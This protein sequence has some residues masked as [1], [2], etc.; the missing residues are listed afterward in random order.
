[1][2]LEQPSSSSSSSDK[3][4]KQSSSSLV[5]HPKKSIKCI[6]NGWFTETETFWPGQ[7]FSLALE[8]F[9]HD[10][11]ILFHDH[12]EHQEILV[13]QSAQYGTTLVLDGVIQLTQRDEFSYHEMMTH[14][15]MCAH[16]SHPQRVLIVGGG[17]GGILREV[18][19]YE[20]VQEI[21][22]VEIDTMVIQVCQQY[23]AESTAVAFQDPRVTIVQADAAIYLA[24]HA[25]NYFDIILGD[26]SDPGTLVPITHFVCVCLSVCFV[27]S[28][29]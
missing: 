16:A 1:L 18:C 5:S 10:Q 29:L 17:D 3:P 21:V 13:F 27:P 9:S 11:A 25:P 19:R 20:C 12:S 22:V 6:H 14:L 7:K 15:P 8:G 4:K 23:F 24:N 26:T 2:A 28:L